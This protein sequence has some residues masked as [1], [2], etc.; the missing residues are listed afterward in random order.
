MQKKGKK[1]LTKII[2]WLAAEILLGFLG[3]DS[4]ADY[5][6]YLFGQDTAV[7]LNCYWKQG[8]KTTAL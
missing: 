8:F 1:F 6:E 3:L 5:S 7:L 4:L 2:L